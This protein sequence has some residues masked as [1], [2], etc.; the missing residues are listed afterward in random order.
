MANPRV[1]FV[2]VENANRSQMAEAWA[3]LLGGEAVEAFSAGSR[4]AGV[5]NPNALAA[6]REVGFD[7]TSQRSKSLTDLP[8]IEFDLVVFM[9]CGDSCPQVRARRHVTWAIPDPKSMPL[10]EVRRIRDLIGVQ[11]RQVLTELGVVLLETH[12]PSR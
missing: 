3:R 10:E 1:L 5:I 9:G 6:M 4:P 7:L 2:C 8:D 11:V 12:K